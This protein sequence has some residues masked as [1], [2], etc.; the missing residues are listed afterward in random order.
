MA[1]V[2]CKLRLVVKTRAKIGMILLKVVNLFFP[3]EIEVR[4]R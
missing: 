1:S 3:L 2:N 4:E